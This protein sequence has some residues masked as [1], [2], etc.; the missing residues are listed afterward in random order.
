MNSTR[1][2]ERRSGRGEL[3]RAA[4]VFAALG[5][6]TRLALV[7]RLCEDGPQSIARLTRHAGV[8]RQAVSKHLRVLEEAGLACGARDGRDVVRRID[9]RG[10]DDSRRWLD[11]IGAHW[12]EALR[13]LK[14]MLENQ[15]TPSRTASR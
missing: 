9:T 4:P 1:R 8:T 14:V 13:R 2:K 3:A 10:L 12:D 11:H 15:D 5:D 7:V 6:R